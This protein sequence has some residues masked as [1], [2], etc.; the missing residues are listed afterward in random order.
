MKGEVIEKSIS[1]SIYWYEKA[2]QQNDPRAAYNLAALYEN[3]NDVEKD[4]NKAYRYYELAYAMGLDVAKS[5]M[6]DLKDKME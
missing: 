2:L 3:G 6:N 5:K 1:K 4:I